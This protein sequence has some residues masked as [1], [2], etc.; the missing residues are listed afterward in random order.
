MGSYRIVRFY[1]SHPRGIRRETQR[2]GLSL[3]EAQSHCS[4]PETSS[5]TATGEAAVALTASVGDWFDGYEDDER[6]GRRPAPILSQLAE[7]MAL[8]RR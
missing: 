6:R 5:R 8:E 3:V 2:T 4:D 1:R 7:I